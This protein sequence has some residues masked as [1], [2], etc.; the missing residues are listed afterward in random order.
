VFG[1][2]LIALNKGAT[3]AELNEKLSEV[4]AAVR[5]TA[6]SGAVSLTLKITPGSKG[7][8]DMVFIEPDVKIKIPS[9]PKGATLFFTTD[10]NRL[11]RRDERQEELP[12]DAANVRVIEMKPETQ[13]KEAM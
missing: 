13:V 10:D 9:A 5:A 12:F 6:K 1:D 3:V 8:A 2:T 4:V 7:N 11:T